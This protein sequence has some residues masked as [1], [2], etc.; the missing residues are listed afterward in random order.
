ME[1]S[2]TVAKASWGFREFLQVSGLTLGAGL[3]SMY[4]TQKTIIKDLDSMEKA[5]HAMAEET[6]YRAKRDAEYLEYKIEAYRERHDA[7]C[8]EIRRRLGVLELRAGIAE[9][10]LGDTDHGR[11]DPQ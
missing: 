5:I 9:P 11:F 4:V 3:L 2:E 10:A 8:R 1:S 7:E 6:R